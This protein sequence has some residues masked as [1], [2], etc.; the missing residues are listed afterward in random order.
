MSKGIPRPERSAWLRVVDRADSPQIDLRV[1]L[2][3]KTVAELRRV[4]EEFKRYRDYY[5]AR[6]DHPRDAIAE[7][8]FVAAL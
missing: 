1:D 3:D 6:C 7:E 2:H 8:D 4:L 5:S